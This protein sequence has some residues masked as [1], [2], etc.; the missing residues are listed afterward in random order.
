MPAWGDTARRALALAVAFALA[1]PAAAQLTDLVSRTAFRVCADPSNLPFSNEAEEGFENAIAS[2]FAERLDRPLQYTWYPMSM[3]FVRRTLLENRCDVIPGYAQGDELV[4]NTNHYYTSTHVLIVRADGDLA[5]VT[6]LADPRLKG[7]RIG[8][9]AGT[10]PASHL[11]RH[12]LMATVKGFHLMV[13]TRHEHPN[14]E[15]I[16]ELIAGELDA[17]VQWGPAGG[18]LAR[19][20]G[21]ALKVTPLIGEEGSPRLFYR[22]TMGVRQGEDVWKRE[23]NTQIRA[24]QPEIDAILTDFGVPLV[25]DMGTAMKAAATP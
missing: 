15:M 23:L 3:G 11:A 20:E 14:S 4:L 13:D 9:I 8:V 12:G 22:I 18:P 16:A 10:P 21:D 6:T 5:D 17:A 7:R 1:V 2:L 19:A 24:L 25:N